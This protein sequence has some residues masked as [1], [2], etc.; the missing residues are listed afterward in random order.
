M[1]GKPVEGGVTA[2]QRPSFIPLS[3][4]LR[5]CER[6]VMGDNVVHEPV[7]ILLY[8]SKLHTRGTDARGL[9]SRAPC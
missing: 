4:A 5:P 1:A 2:F 6:S 3:P 7:S 8:I 9:L